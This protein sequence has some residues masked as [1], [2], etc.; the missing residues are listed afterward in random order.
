MILISADNKNVTMKN[1]DVDSIEDENSNIK[2]S[3]SSSTHISAAT[4]TLLNRD[5]YIKIGSADTLLKE[6]GIMSKDGK[7]KNDKIR[8]YNQIDH[9]VELLEGILDKL[10][11]NQV[12]NILD[13]GCGKSY[14]SFVLNYY[15]TEVK[16]KKCHFI[17]LDYS[18]D[19]IESSKKMAS[20]LNYRNMEFHAIDINEIF[21][22]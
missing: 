16:R 5:Y 4:S 21:P 14:L 8:K 1:L 15:L 10:P 17:G 12:V 13:C 2:S 11:Q 6:I 19:V 22:K 3:K 9:Y 7:I 20:N 18:E